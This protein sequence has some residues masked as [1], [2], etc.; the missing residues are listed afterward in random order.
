[1]SLPSIRTDRRFRG[2]LV[3]FLDDC[4][5]VVRALRHA[6]DAIGRHQR[7]RALGFDRMLDAILG[8]TAPASIGTPRHQHR[9][10]EA[11]GRD[12]AG[13]RALPRQDRVVDDSRAVHE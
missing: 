9:I 10:L 8:K 4:A 3:E 1:M 6:D 12:Q 11:A 5:L 2:R 7:R 13:A